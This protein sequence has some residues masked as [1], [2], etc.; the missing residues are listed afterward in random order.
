MP[1]DDP[2]GKLHYVRQSAIGFQ[3]L[4]DNPAEPHSGLNLN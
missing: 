1:R 3:M 4:R 2:G